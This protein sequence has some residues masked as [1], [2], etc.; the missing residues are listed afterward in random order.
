MWCLI[1]DTPDIYILFIK[2]IQ[3]YIKCQCVI[4][5]PV[6]VPNRMIKWYL[7]DAISRSLAASE[8]PDKGWR[9][10]RMV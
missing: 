1:F 2:S 3:L 10:K 8:D 6:C 5:G 7:K 9:A 4:S